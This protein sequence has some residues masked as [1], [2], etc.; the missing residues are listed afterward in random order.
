MMRVQDVRINRS[1]PLG[2]HRLTDLC[3][4]IDR[5]P[6]M[7]KI[8][9]RGYKRILKNQRIR[10]SRTKMYAYIDDNDGTIVISQQYLRKGR[11]DYLCLDLI[12]ELVHIRQF[13]EGKD[14][15]D[16]RFRYLERPT[17]IEAYR[18]AA[19]EAKKMGMRG[20]ELREYLIVEWVTEDEFAKLLKE[21]GVR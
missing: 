19:A 11:L 1:L 9:G 20:R 3:D 15:F 8:F 10:I 5:L 4:H 21:I 6:I 2:K 13:H 14:L 7:K 17:E 16:K 12:H 18:T